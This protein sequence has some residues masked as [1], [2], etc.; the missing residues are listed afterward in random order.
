MGL[1][2]LSFL[3]GRLCI[4]IQGFSYPRLLN[5]LSGRGIYIWNIKEVPGGVQLYIFFKDVKALR[6]L[7]KKAGVRE[8]I[9]NSF[10]LPFIISRICKKY[11]FV[12]GAL[13]FILFLTI[14]TRFVWLIEVDGNYRVSTGAI[15]SLCEKMELDY[16]T[17]KKS[18]DTRLIENEIKNNFK[19]ISF[20][21]V[22][23][24]GTKVQINVSETIPTD[25]SIEDGT[26]PADIVSSDNAVVTGV[27]VRAG[28][29]VVTEGMSVG[30]GDILVNADVE[31][32]AE[33][34]VL[35]TKAVR[36]DG[37]VYGRVVEKYDFT[38]PFDE[39]VR[40]YEGKSKARY[41][42]EIFDK[43][44]SLN[45][46]KNDTI[47]EKCDKIENKL[48]PHLPGD[49][50]LPFIIDRTVY[51]PYR[52]EP[53]RLSPEEAKKR[54][55]SI[56]MAEIVNNY[57]TDADVLGKELAFEEEENDLKVSAKITVVKQIGVLKAYERINENG[58]TED[59]S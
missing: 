23:V 54:A 5:M 51:R 56:V 25:N 1:F 40:I 39:N 32:K 22:T 48:Q 30:K 28:R 49:I 8:E 21:S 52:L 3:F 34:E 11:F 45:F 57:P 31:I 38:V 7:C 58:N 13:F 15:L 20:V 35:G 26:S 9:V 17:Y 41:E 29:P 55:E 42:F 6:G 50:Y 2:L 59:R 4:K 18:I 16:G 27:I 24:K 10:G 19:D 12:A 33:Q 44:I 46:N 43:K 53:K 37:E 14:I 47:S 36:C